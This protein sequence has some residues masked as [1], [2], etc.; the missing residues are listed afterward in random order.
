MLERR[1]EILPVISPAVLFCV[2]N[3]LS[4]ILKK[5]KEVCQLLGR[6]K[7]TSEVRTGMWMRTEFPARGQ[8]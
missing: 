4:A 2:R 5:T 3:A 7:R 8:R 1:L 6:G